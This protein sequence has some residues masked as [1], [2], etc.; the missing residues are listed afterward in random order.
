MTVDLER[1][2]EA[3]SLAGAVMRRAGQFKGRPLDVCLAML[4]LDVCRH[5]GE[6]PERERYA[7]ACRCAAD[8]VAARMRETGGG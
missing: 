2:H 4:R 3:L 8:I 1:G 7:Q 5:R 6:S